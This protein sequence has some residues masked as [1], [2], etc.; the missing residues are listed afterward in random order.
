MSDR[1]EVRPVPGLA[2]ASARKRADTS[3]GTNDGT[4]AATT[5][6]HGPR[7]EVIAT[8]ENQKRKAVGRDKA[9]PP[10]P[11]EWAEEQLKKAPPRS[12]EWA[13]R[14]ARIWGLE[15]D[16]KNPEEKAS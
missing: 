6:R 15:L 7:G 10:T 1:P 13:R 4:S 14:V 12:T 3:H 11:E 16:E 9:I 2:R 8:A 5:D